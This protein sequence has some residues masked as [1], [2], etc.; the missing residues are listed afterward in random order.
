MKILIH[1]INFSPELT[2][3][4][5]YT[6]DMAFWLA[7]NGHQVEVITAIPYYPDWRI[8]FP[9]FNF[10]K[11]EKSSNLLVMRGPLYVPKSLTA[12]KRIIHESTFTISTL[13]YWLR[14]IFIKYDVVFVVSPA[15]QS[16]IIPSILKYFKKF[17]LI[18]HVQDLQVDAAKQLGMV[19][20]EVLISILEKVE[21]FILNRADRVSTISEGMR[22]KIV[23]KGISFDKTFLIKN[24]VDVDAIF[25]L[26]GHE[27]NKIKKEW[28]FAFDD[29]II[30]YSGNMG[31]KQ[32]L[33]AVIEVACILK[34]RNNIKF[35]LVGEG[36]SKLRLLNMAKD[37]KLDNVRFEP[38][39]GYDRLNELLNLADLH[40]VLQKSGA[41]DL[42]MPSKLGGILSVGG[43][44][45][46][47]TDIESDLYNIITKNKLGKCILPENVNA[48]SQSL[49]E[50]KESDLSDYKFSARKF[51]ESEL[52]KQV[53][54]Q[55]LKEKLIYLNN[56]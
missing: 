49:L 39:V 2:G 11:I 19:R 56:G 46:V 3:I 54:L 27:I 45:I 13:I 44:S 55:S 51:A 23:N 30:L 38:L 41:T 22:K 33:E 25:P 5:K 31:E 17:K 20:S 28:G 52:S 12:L 36:S 14:V 26:K 50:A 40:L 8:K 29:F 42:V 24:W 48:L 53:I 37:A 21:S 6:G 32:G 9:Y 43:M 34:N 15:L 7:E 4:G 16:G 18:F 1:G 47:A 35:L 10:W